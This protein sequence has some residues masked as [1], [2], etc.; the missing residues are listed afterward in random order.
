VRAN[1][2]GETAIPGLFACGE[3]AQEGLNGGNRL[4][5]NSLTECLVFG[6][7][8]GKVASR[9]AQG[10]GQLPLAALEKQAN[11]EERRV[12]GQ[13]FEANNGN[14]RV[15]LIRTDLQQAM[16]RNVGVYRTKEGLLQA[17]QDVRDLQERFRHVRLD[18]HSKV[19]N[20]ELTAALELENLLDIAETVVAPA[21]LREESR[22]SQAR[23]DFPNRDDKN[24][25]AHSLIF[26][27]PD[28]PRVEWQD[29]VLEWPGAVLTEL[30]PKE[31]VY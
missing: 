10:V 31:R 5:S 8:T 15:G 18:D 14:E 30:V 6:N 22:G 2:D 23:R 25:L 16:E 9:Y 28:G 1:L 13:F 4:G 3:C 12:I 27:T 29:A 20:T 7:R 24:F 26:R 11:E 19:F 21:I 17:A